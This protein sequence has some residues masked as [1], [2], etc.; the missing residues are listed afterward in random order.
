MMGLDEGLAD[1]SMIL[2]QSILN[3]LT[4]SIWNEIGPLSNHHS[5][6]SLNLVLQQVCQTRHGGE[7]VS[8]LIH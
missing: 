4:A 8:M 6:R 5:W 3:S 2:S 7:D 1:S